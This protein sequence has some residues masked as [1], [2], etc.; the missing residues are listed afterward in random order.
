MAIST[1]TTR[2]TRQ[3]ARVTIVVTR[4]VL[5]AIG[6]KIDIDGL[7]YSV[8]N[9][10]GPLKIPAAGLL[11]DE[12]HVELDL[13]EAG[14][15]PF[16]PLLPRAR[17]IIERHGAAVEALSSTREGSMRRVSIHARATWPS[18]TVD[19]YGTGSNDHAALDDLENHMQH[20]GPER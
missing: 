9:V 6:E 1:R 14:P 3:G 15:S 4:Q 12:F 13:E 11:A 7:R 2:P 10:R 5:P 17:A 8:S 19:V 16:D 20:F 18:R